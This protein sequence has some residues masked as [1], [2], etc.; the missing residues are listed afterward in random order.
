MK[1]KVNY[2][3]F[4]K[5][6]EL[7][8][9]FCLKREIYKF[10]EIMPFLFPIWI[11]LDLFSKGE[12]DI[13]ENLLLIPETCMIRTL[14]AFIGSIALKRI[15]KE[16]AYEKLSQLSTYM[17]SLEISTSPELL[18]DSK[19]YEKEY[20]LELN[21]KKLPVLKQKKYIMIK[22][23]NDEEVSILQEHNIGSREWKISQDE[24]TK[25]YKLSFAKSS[26]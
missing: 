6:E 2:D 9:G 12:T 18:K 20:K 8:T 1:I 17:Q 21:D 24:P 3:L 15:I 10:L 5:L 22:T 19:V 13:L 26:I 14:F 25:V 11:S 23:R 4:E 16:S 7:E